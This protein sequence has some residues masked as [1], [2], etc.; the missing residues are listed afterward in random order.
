MQRRIPRH[1]SSGEWPILR[2]RHQFGSARIINQVK[3]SPAERAALTLLRPQYLVVCLML[4]SM[5][6][7]R[8]AQMLAQKFHPVALVRIAP[9]SHP[10]EMNVI[11]HQAVSG[12]E[13]TFAR[14]N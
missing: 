1:N 7:Q 3:A 14:G 5:R 10:N 12:T 11:G 2:S 13:Q 6:A 9:Q 4:K 8:R